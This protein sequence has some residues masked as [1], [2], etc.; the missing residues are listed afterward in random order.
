[1]FL[2]EGSSDNDITPH[3]FLA[4][5]PFLIPLFAIAGL[6]SDEFLLNDE[7]WIIKFP[8]LRQ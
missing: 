7:L 8:I 6:L 1:M 5:V 2:V 4:R 3:I